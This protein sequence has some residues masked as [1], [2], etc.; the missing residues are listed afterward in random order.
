M[1]TES[2]PSSMTITPN[3]RLTIAV[4]LIIA[5]TVASVVGWAYR[6][7]VCV[8][9]SLTYEEASEHFVTDKEYTTQMKAMDAQ[10]QKIDHDVSYIRDRVDKLK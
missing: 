1:S 5:G 2:R 3:T 9:N 4:V 10:L 8:D 7:E 6:I